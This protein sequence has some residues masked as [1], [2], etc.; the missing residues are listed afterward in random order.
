MAAAHLRHCIRTAAELEEHL[1]R[2]EESSS[3]TSA[4]RRELDLFSITRRSVPGSSTGTRA[5]HGADVLENF[6]KESTTARLP[7]RVHAAHRQRKALRDLGAPR[8]TTP[9]S[10]TRRW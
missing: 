2:I 3:A 6:W 8:E 10:C 1:K 9:T 7:V 4:P 5:R